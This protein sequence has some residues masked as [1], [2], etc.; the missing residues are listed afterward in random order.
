MLIPVQ[1]DIIEMESSHLP[2]ASDRPMEGSSST[3]ADNQADD[4][5]VTAINAD[6]PFPL[7]TEDHQVPLQA[8]SA[9]RGH[10]RKVGMEDKQGSIHRLNLPLTLG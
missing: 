5:V 2:I 7:V 6:L 1:P 10:K 9:Q 3:L 4:P 8:S